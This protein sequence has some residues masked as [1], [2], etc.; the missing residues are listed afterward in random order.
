MCLIFFGRIGCWR[1]DRCFGCPFIRRDTSFRAVS[2][3]GS[4][5]DSCVASP[6]TELFVDLVIVDAL[7]CFVVNTTESLVENLAH[8]KLSARVFISL[9]KKLLLLMPDYLCFRLSAK[10]HVSLLF[11][12]NILV[13][14]G[15]PARVCFLEDG[16]RLWNLDEVNVFILG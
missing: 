12:R 14:L 3:V 10:S 7:L 16:V 2:V 4:L 11:E 1:L 8:G 13:D 6:A 5:A 15:Q 9:C